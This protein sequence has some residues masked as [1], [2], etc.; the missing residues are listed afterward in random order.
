MLWNFEAGSLLEAGAPI[1]QLGWQVA[2]PRGPSL[3]LPL[4]PVLELQVYM[5]SPQLLCGCSRP[6]AYK[7]PLT[8]LQPLYEVSHGGSALSLQHPAL[9]S[10]VTEPHQVIPPLTKLFGGCTVTSEK[11]SLIRIE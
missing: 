6:H 1:S 4:S 11:S 7:Q 3:A 9:P 2:S 8:S 5:G 10:L